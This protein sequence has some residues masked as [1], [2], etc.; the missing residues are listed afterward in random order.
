MFVESYDWKYLGKI[1]ASIALSVIVGL[2]WISNSENQAKIVKNPQ[3]FSLGQA[4]RQK[5]TDRTLVV[6][7]AS[8]CASCKEDLEELK[9]FSQSGLPKGFSILA[10]NID[11]AKNLPEAKFMW[12]QLEIKGIELIYD[13]RE[14]HQNNLLVDLLP[15]YFLFD[16]DGKTLL[17]LEGNVDLSDPKLL[18]LMFN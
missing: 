3:D 18:S 12:S 16:K 2:F 10:V 15:T 8:W 7:W 5:L 4:F 13:E 14:E 9:A 1:A 11:E 6:F 17:R